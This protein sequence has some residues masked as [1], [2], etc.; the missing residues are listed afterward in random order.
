[1]VGLMVAV[2]GVRTLVSVFHEFTEGGLSGR[3]VAAVE[4]ALR[5]LSGVKAW[6]ELR[7]RRVGRETFV[8]LHVLVDPT[9][10]VV[11]AHRV[12]MEVEEAIRRACRRPV[13]TV[14]HIEPNLD[15]LAAHHSAS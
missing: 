1:V 4:A 13:N 14:V 3:D 8:D 12:S 6:H 9:L 5:S 11:D 2:A 7:G 10:T 15:E